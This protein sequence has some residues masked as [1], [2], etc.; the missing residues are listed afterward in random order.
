MALAKAEQLKI[1]KEVLDAFSTSTGVFCRIIGSKGETVAGSCC[2][3]SMC[4]ACRLIQDA[5]A[6][7]FDCERHFV[8]G[9]LQAERFG[10][11]Y[12][13]YCPSGMTYFTAMIY[14]S[15][16]AQ[17]CLCA[18]P[19]LMAE[20]EDYLAYDIDP[21]HELSKADTDRV[22]DVLDKVPSFSPDRV[23]A[24]SKILT[25]AAFYLS[26]RESYE[27]LD[28]E[29][30]VILQSRIGE[31]VQDI[32]TE[33]DRGYPFDKEKELLQSIAEGDRET[34]S[35]LLN[36]ILGYVFFSSGGD[37]SVIKTR[38]TEL[39]VLLSRSVLTV[40]AQEQDVFYLN[41]RY[42]EELSRIDNLDRLTDWLSGILSRFNEITF[43]LSDVKHTDTLYKVIGFIKKNYMNRLTIEDIAAHVHFSPSYLSRIFKAEFNISLNAYLNQVRIGKS[44]ALLLTDDIPL[45][46]IPM[47]VGYEDQ[48]Y[49]SKVFKK[50]TGTTPGRF[51]ETRGQSVSGEKKPLLD[52]KEA[53]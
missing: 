50:L 18:G 1:Y 41:G 40:G 16:E 47:L 9:F 25:V 26:G 2:G 52:Y 13:Y 51:R 21:A 32:K 10:G 19:L 24:L 4:D 12:I 44:K 6:R 34:A 23:T 49:F 43:T 11:R 20:K 45:S 39:I 37:F 15:G 36:D 5:T 46:Q 8:Y 7:R 48:S 17:Y 14:T 53:E 30:G 3:Q 29:R 22:R 42:L 27:L 28:R 38:V 35:R 33:P 31:A